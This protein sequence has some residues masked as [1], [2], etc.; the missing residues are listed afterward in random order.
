MKEPGEKTGKA[1]E[2]K[3]DYGNRIVFFNSFEEMN[4]YDHRYYASLH[5]EES[6]AQV[7]EMRLARFPHLNQNLNP[8]GTQIYF[9]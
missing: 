1:E 9:D 8:W 4:E 5:P 7:T 3:P 6:L 2:P